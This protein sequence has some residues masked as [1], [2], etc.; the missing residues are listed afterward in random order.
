[1][2]GGEG[3]GDGR[4]ETENEDGRRKLEEG[5][6]TGDGRPKMTMPEIH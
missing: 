3:T 6:K 4:R 1:M 2:E 5:R